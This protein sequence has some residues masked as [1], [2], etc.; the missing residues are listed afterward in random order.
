MHGIILGFMRYAD[1]MVI[2]AYLLAITWFGSRF[3]RSQKT[4]RDYFLGGKTAPWWA[5]AFSIVSAE[6]STLTVVGTPA[7]AFRG[8]IGI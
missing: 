8:N 1:L 7:L 6:T 5:I 4:L 2:A 3:K